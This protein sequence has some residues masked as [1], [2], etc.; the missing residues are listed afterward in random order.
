MTSKE[1]RTLKSNLEKLE[2]FADLVSDVIKTLP[3]III[4]SNF[5][6]FSSLFS[7]LVYRLM[8]TMP[9]MKEKN[10]NS[11]EEIRKIIAKLLEKIKP[12]FMKKT[13]QASVEILKHKL[14]LRNQR[15]TKR[16][17][18]ILMVTFFEAYLKDLFI[19]RVNKEHKYA[20][21]FLEKDLK[22]KD[23]KE[24]GFDLS[25]N[26]GNVIAN[27]INFQDI[28]EVSRVY[29]CAFGVD[30]FNKNTALKN[31]LKRLFQE[32]HIIVHNNGMIDKK[33]I[34]ILKCKKS[35]LGKG[36]TITKSNLSDYNKAVLKIAE[37][38][39]K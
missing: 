26:M 2:V 21:P 38:I 18:V 6:F 20:L 11:N 31:K 8:T 5:K 12:D 37:N 13:K 32:R 15:L 7:N 9:L 25:K 36:I 28:D 4:E 24:Y 3:E 17:S 27:K 39:E 22:I 14:F 33:Y 1:Y 29:Q 23:I 34:L 10:K 30:I 35:R 19:V 16:A